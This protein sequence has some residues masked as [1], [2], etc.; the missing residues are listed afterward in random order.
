MKTR[1]IDG[2]GDECYYCDRCNEEVSEYDDYCVVCG[3]SLAE[4]TTPFPL[5]GNRELRESNYT[6]SYKILSISETSDSKFSRCLY[7]EANPVK[8]ISAGIASFTSV[9]ESICD[10]TC[11]FIFPSTQ[12]DLEYL[13]NIAKNSLWQVNLND[14]EFESAM[15]R[16]ESYIMYRSKK[17]FKMNPPIKN[18]DDDS[19]QLENFSKSEKGVV[20]NGVKW[21]TRNID[22]PGSFSQNPEDYG[23]YYQF[24]KGTTDY[25][26]FNDYWNSVYANSNLWLPANDPSPEGWRLPTLAEIQKLR[27]TNNVASEWI[28]KN[29]LIGRKFFDKATGNNIFLPAAGYCDNYNGTLRGVGSYGIYWSSMVYDRDCAYLLRFGNGFVGRSTNSRSNGFSVRVVAE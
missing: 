15:L 22:T 1:R 17:F 19:S 3:S 9:K 23:G 29:G 21:A 6:N 2:F 20:I 25:L 7:V 27:D 8:I 26:F 12:E 16:G 24:N 5:F 11:R 13:T 14:F 10:E 28:K 4:V 18:S